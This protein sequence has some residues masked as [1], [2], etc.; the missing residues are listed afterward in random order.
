VETLTLHGANGEPLL[1]RP[2]E[3][4]HLPFL[5]GKDIETGDTMNLNYGVHTEVTV[6]HWAPELREAMLSAIRDQLIPPPEKK[7]R[8]T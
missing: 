2:V 5:V 4:G 1:T 8:L 3:E 7:R 6:G